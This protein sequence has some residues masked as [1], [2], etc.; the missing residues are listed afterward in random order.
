[1]G[2]NHGADSLFPCPETKA[3]RSIKMNSREYEEYHETREEL[4]RS[5]APPRKCHLM[6]MECQYAR[7]FELNEEDGKDYEL[8]CQYIDNDG[9]EG[10]E[11]CP[12]DPECRDPEK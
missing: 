8:D 2:F 9:N 4:L 1:M 11:F 3:K 12:Y 6:N 7:Y 5:E 10:D